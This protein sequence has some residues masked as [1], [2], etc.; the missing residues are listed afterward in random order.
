MARTPDTA[1][2]MSAEQRGVPTRYLRTVGLG[3]YAERLVPVR[4]G[5]PYWSPKTWPGPAAGRGDAA[6][7][8]AVPG[9]YPG[10]LVVPAIDWSGGVVSCFAA[11]SEGA[12]VARDGQLV[13]PASAS[14]AWRRATVGHG[15]A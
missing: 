12:R 9:L 4:P 2:T 13:N 5:Q 7:T 11:F 6:V 14:A 15:A 1:R 3:A 10:L 8:R